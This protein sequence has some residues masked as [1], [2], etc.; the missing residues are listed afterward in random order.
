MLY[1]VVNRSIEVT[2]PIDFEVCF[3]CGAPALP[4]CDST[5]HNTVF[6]VR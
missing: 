5:D 4:A 3:V 1:G 6:G 2:C